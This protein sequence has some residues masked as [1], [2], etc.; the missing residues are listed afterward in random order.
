M[1]FAWFG[2]TRRCE[3][4]NDAGYSRYG[5]RGIRMIWKSFE[6]FKE[7]MQIGFLVHIEKHGKR[8]T[9]LERIDNDGNYSKENCRWATW[10]EQSANRHISERKGGDIF[11]RSLSKKFGLPYQMLMREMLK[12]KLTTNQA[13]NNCLK[14]LI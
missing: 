9:T 10:E 3:N 6:D 12:K 11:V 1:Y 14:K 7:D 13:V 4:K 2:A 5:G 8:N